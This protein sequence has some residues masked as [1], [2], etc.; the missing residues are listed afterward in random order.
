MLSYNFRLIHELINI[1]SMRS[2][3]DLSGPEIPKIA[4]RKK[5]ICRYG[6]RR[7]TCQLLVGATV[8]LGVYDPFACQKQEETTEDRSVHQNHQPMASSDSGES[9]EAWG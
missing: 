2:S 8:E 9:D 7:L 1:K 5:L 6:N 4:S 3:I